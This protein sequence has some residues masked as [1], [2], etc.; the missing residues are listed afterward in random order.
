MCNDASNAG[1]IAKSTHQWTLR[2]NINGDD[3]DDGQNASA[4]ALK[5]IAM[6][7]VQCGSYSLYRTNIHTETAQK[8]HT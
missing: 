3:D 2:D 7:C 6:I 5:S 8:E 4:V 1:C